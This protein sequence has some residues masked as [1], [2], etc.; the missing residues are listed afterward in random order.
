MM[1]TKSILCVL[2]VAMAMFSSCSEK[3]AEVQ[4]V[5]NQAYTVVSDSIYSRMPGTILY[6]DG[7]VYWEDA[8]AFEKFVHAV[9]VNKQMEIA[10]FANKGE[11]PDDF[12][13]PLMSLSPSGGL[14]VND[15]NKPLEILY[16]VKEEGLSV[17][18]R[19]YGNDPMATRLLHLDGGA[20][21]FLC[22]EKDELFHIYAKD[23]PGISFGERPIKDEMNNAY[24]VFQGIVDYH[25][26][27]KLL[28][29][30]SLSFPYLAVF[31]Q[32][33][34]GT[35]ERIGEKREDW[36]Y[37]FS[38]GSLIFAPDAKKG[39]MEM[40]LTDDYV[41]LLQRDTQVEE[42]VSRKEEGRSMALLPRSLFVYD[43][44]LKLKKIINMP[45]PMLRLCGDTDTNTLY[46]MSVNPEFELIS[47]DLE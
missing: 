24:D 21:L 1:K 14:Y 43:Y 41:V 28:V 47:I 40:A 16:Q 35:W 12:T 39:A 42:S 18:S 5:S 4:R 15:G 38:D 29:Y 22:P 19:K 44:N 17:Q 31:R 33:D 3:N 34:K 10:C 32:S 36:D 25:A 11:G 6:Q 37:T 2:V 8:I 27:K 7:I 23:A 9:D 30:S 20:T 46:A 13:F 26:E 45:F